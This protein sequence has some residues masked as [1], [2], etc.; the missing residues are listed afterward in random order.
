MSTNNREI[1]LLLPATGEPLI[2][3]FWL[4]NYSKYSHL[5]NNTYIAVDCMGKLNPMEFLFIKNYLGRQFGKYSIRDHYNYALGQH[6]HNIDSLLTRF[7]PDIK[8]NIL[9][10]EEDDYVLNPALL[11]IEIKEYFDENYDVL[12]CPRGSCTPYMAELIRQYVYSKS[13]FYLNTKLRKDEYTLNFWPT[14]LLTKKKH[15]FNS[16]RNFCAKSWPVGTTLK[17]GDSE[18]VLTEDCNGDTM[19]GFSMELYQNPEVKR[20]KM[21][22]E[23]YHSKLEDNE[24]IP[25]ILDTSLDFHVGSL[26]SMLS[27]RLW[28]P[29]DGVWDENSSYVAYMRHVQQFDYGYR[30]IVEMYRR[31]LLLRQMLYALKKPEEFEFFGNYEG[32]LDE[33]IGIFEAENDMQAMLDKFGIWSVAKGLDEDIYGTVCKRLV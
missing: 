1:S 10:M 3:Q 4:Q 11:E 24:F 30:E 32:R 33:I 19:V 23:L 7:E 6:G 28:K 13:D 21:L 25:Q 9:L 26:S 22:H 18:T 17:L 15:F 20:V 31:L 8:E 2:M 12:G 29:T 14:L 16:S 27:N 5:V